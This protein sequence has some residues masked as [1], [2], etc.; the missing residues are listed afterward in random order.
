MAKSV[1]KSISDRGVLTVTFNRQ[2]RANSYDASMLDTLAHIIQESSD[3]SSLRLIV[4][5]GA[6]K[7]FSG[8]AAIGTDDGRPRQSIGEVCELIDRSP[9]P[10]LAVVQGACIGGALALACSCDFILAARNATFS[11]PEV[12]LGFSPGP[13]IGVFL[14]AMG[15]RALRRHL[16]S[17]DQFSAQEAFRIGLA[18]ELCETNEIDTALEKVVD[19]FLLG[20]P[21]A[22]SSAKNALRNYAVPAPLSGEAMRELQAA[23][24]LVSNSEEAKEGRAAFAEKRRPSWYF[25]R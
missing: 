14:R 20:A 3:S 10:T 7:H 17:G 15:Y 16:L 5:R 6:G 9:K 19:Q 18:H 25:D 11:I 12:R 8:G 22:L 21:G 13:L 24:D 4:L 2:D 23:F 1:L